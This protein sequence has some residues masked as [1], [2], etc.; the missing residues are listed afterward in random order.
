LIQSALNRL[1]VVDAA[2]AT[3]A[4][5]D[6]ARI[7]RRGFECRR[8]REG[9]EWRRDQRKEAGQPKSSLLHDSFLWVPS[10]IPGGGK[11]SRDC[12]V[13]AAIRETARLD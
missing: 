7:S 1:S 5:C 8:R 10:T 4:D 6:G 9:R 13:A 3:S 11:L 12:F 2:V